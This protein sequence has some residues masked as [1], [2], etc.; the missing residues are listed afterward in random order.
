M[1]QSNIREDLIAT[2]LAES[3]VDSNYA[4]YVVSDHMFIL[5]FTSGDNYDE[6][7][8]LMNL[9]S[10]SLV[11]NGAYAVL[12]VTNSFK[13]GSFTQ[14]LSAYKDPFAQKVNN[15]TGSA[16]S[17]ATPSTP[18]AATAPA[19]PSSGAPSIYQDTPAG[20]LG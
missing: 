8:G 14:M 11:F 9:G 7:T 10:P 15:E 16:T 12:E 6:D 19:A 5:S 1:G 17:S 3:S 2:T 13:G 4:N 20:A 18:T